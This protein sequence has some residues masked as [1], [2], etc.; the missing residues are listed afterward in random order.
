MTNV[1]VSNNVMSLTDRNISNVFTGEKNPFSSRVNLFFP[2]MF[3]YLR[4]I[5]M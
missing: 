3:I 4:E 2:Q 1:R 5:Y